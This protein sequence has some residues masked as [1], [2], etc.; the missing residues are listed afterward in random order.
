MNTP[1]LIISLFFLIQTSNLFCQEQ[2]IFKDKFQE[3]T[4]EYQYY[5]ND[6]YE[7]IY[8]GFFKYN[9]EKYLAIGQY[10]DNLPE[11]NWIISA[12]N[13][14]YSNWQTKIQTNTLVKGA[15][16]AGLLNGLWVYKNSFS[17]PDLETNKFR[18]GDEMDTDIAE[19]TFVNN[20][21]VGDIKFSRSFEKVTIT[22]S[23]DNKGLMKGLWTYKK[24]Y[25]ED[26]IKYNN[27]VAYWRLIRELPTGKK[28]LF[29]DSTN[30]VNKFWA[31]FDSTSNVSQF[32]GKVYYAEKVKLN[33]ST[34]VGNS[35]INLTNDNIN[36]SRLFDNPAISIWQDVSVDVYQSYNATN[37]LYYGI[38]DSRSPIAYEILIKECSY[39]SSNGQFISNESCTHALNN[40]KKH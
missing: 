20:I 4:S 32:D 14:V 12:N 35:M 38:R 21:F 7:I 3:G 29:V 5:V 36:Y 25:E 16:S 30:F 23:F 9:G 39:S 28:T 33:G 1:R 18:I 2:K 8:N 11:G 31:N 27:G 15:Y 26:I 37:P 24:D 17:L 22:G 10:K 19:A 34:R 6:N 40:N 13:K